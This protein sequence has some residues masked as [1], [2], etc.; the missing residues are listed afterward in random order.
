[1]ADPAI[2][3]AI[4]A[5]VAKLEAI[6][7]TIDAAQ[8]FRRRGEKAPP[9]TRAGKRSFDFG[10]VGMRD[11]S[12]EGAPG[13]VQNPGKADRTASIAITIDYPLARAEKAL[14]TTMAVDSELVL[15]ALGR[16]ANWAGTVVQRVVAKT[17]VNRAS[18]ELLIEDQVQPGFLRLVVTAEIQYRDSE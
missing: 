14:E 1:V 13:G 9:T 5:V 17:T 12:N 3:S 10:F 6:T 4:D 15:R 11:L 18:S 2:S 7:P 16:S 8:E